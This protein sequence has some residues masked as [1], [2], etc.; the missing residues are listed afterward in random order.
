LV[1]ANPLI[2]N[3]D[4]S[5]SL[6]LTE[7]RRAIKAIADFFYPPIN[8]VVTCLDGKERLLGEEQYLNRLHEYIMNIKNK[9]TSRKLLLL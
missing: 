7:I 6:L 3:D 8:K 1:L 5:Y 2:Q 9:P 4:E